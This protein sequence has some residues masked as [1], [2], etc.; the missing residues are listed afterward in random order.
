MQIVRT[1]ETAAQKERGDLR[2]STRQ[3]QKGQKSG[4]EGKEK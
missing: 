2:P 4:K 3:K 1:M